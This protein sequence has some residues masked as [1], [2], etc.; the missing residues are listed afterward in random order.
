MLIAKEM[1]GGIYLAQVGASVSPGQPGSL[2]NTW[3][4]VGPGKTPRLLLD[5][6]NY[7]LTFNYLGK[8]YARTLVLA[9]WP[10]E[11]VN[12]VTLSPISIQEPSEAQ[13]IPTLTAPSGMIVFD[14]QDHAPDVLRGG[15]YY[16]PST[17]TYSVTLSRDSAI[18]PNPATRQ[19][20]RLYTR[21]IGSSTWTLAVDWS[22][23][24][25][26]YTV[27]NVGSLRIEAAMTY[28]DLWTQPGRNSNL[29]TSQLYRESPVG[30]VLSIDSLIL[31]K[32]YTV[33]ATDG[34]HFG[35]GGAHSLLLTDS[36]EHFQVESFSDHQ[37]VPFNPGSGGNSQF[38]LQ[39]AFKVFLP[40]PSDHQ[41]V[42]LLNAGA[43]GFGSMLL[44]S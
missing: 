24:I 4:Y 31:P 29:P 35:V 23:D 7:I 25:P 1:N 43:Q 36:E 20:Y 5:G 16:D 13:V 10:P 34:G 44:M 15:L 9:T 38:D 21:P 33:S 11:I 8:V 37:S 40:S 39:C 22:T 17:N 28:G 32:T 27:S 3:S 19:K 14:H 18:N 42:L 2:T 6:S 26:A 12:P 41:S 30:P